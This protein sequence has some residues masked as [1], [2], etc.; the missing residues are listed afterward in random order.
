MTLLGL[1]EVRRS[2]GLHWELEPLISGCFFERKPKLGL[3]KANCLISG[4]VGPT[5]ESLTSGFRVRF[6][7]GLRPTRRCSTCR[8][9][10]CRPLW[11]RLRARR[12]YDVLATFSVEA[13]K[14]RRSSCYI[15]YVEK[16][17]FFRDWGRSLEI[18]EPGKKSFRVIVAPRRRKTN[19]LFFSFSLFAKSGK[20]FVSVLFAFFTFSVPDGDI[21]DPTSD[22]VDWPTATEAKSCHRLT[23][24]SFPTELKKK[25][26]RER[27]LLGTIRSEGPIFKH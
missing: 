8:P 19:F 26:K 14:N 13:P 17:F 4:R 15:L 21:K 11:R 27:T 7:R 3:L 6:S 24:L 10:S 16:S 25:E 5:N 18:E 9:C 1:L 20:I 12:L 22:L 2:V 23:R